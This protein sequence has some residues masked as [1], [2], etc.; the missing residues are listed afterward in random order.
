MLSIGAGLVP[1]IG[2]IRCPVVILL[3][4]HVADVVAVHENIWPKNVYGP[5][6]A[7]AVAVPKDAL[8]PSYF[9]NMTYCLVVSLYSTSILSHQ[10]GR[11]QRNALVGPMEQV[12]RSV[13]SLVDPARL[14]AKPVVDAI[15][16]A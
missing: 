3:H 6:G 10:F 7:E 16:L 8:S 11:D 1:N 15:E 14:A 9:K 4:R 13:A 5:S 2:Q 12:G